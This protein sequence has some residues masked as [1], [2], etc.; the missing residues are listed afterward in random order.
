[1][2][3]RA[4]GEA[5]CGKARHKGDSKHKKPVMAP[6]KRGFIDRLQRAIDSVG[7]QKEVQLLAKS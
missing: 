2:L 3:A 4:E 5:K 1:L 7:L 6:L